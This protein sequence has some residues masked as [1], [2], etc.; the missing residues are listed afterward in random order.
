[1]RSG[2]HAQDHKRIRS[3]GWLRLALGAFGIFLILM[4]RT[5]LSRGIIAYDDLWRGPVWSIGL[6]ATGVLMILLVLIP[7]PW[8]D[9][10]VQRN[11]RKHPFR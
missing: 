5:Q 10:L 1:M 4:G 2:H 3:S 9:A 7:S 6:S 11:E 8:I